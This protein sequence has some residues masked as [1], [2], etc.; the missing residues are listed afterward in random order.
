MANITVPAY[1]IFDV[2]DRRDVHIKFSVEGATP[3]EQKQAADEYA[4]AWAKWNEIDYRSVKTFIG[5]ADS[6]IDNI[7]EWFDKKFN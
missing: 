7:K 3:Q 6:N 1:A 2:E 5:V 4:A